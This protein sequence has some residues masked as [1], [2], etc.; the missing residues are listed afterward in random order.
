MIFLFSRMRLL[1]CIRCLLWCL[2]LTLPC[3]G[4]SHEEKWV[5]RVHPPAGMYRA[6]LHFLSY[7]A[8]PKLKGVVVVAPGMNGDPECYM[9]DQGWCEFIKSNDLLMV[10]IS[11]ASEYKDLHD[12]KGYY[13]PSSGSGKV[14]LEGLTR[15]GVGKL[16]MY[17][18]GFSGGAHFVSRFVRWHPDGI[19][20]WCAYSAAWWDR[21]MCKR[22]GVPGIVACGTL[23][24]RLSAS[25]TYFEQGRDCGEIWL[26]VAIE[27]VGH[28][29]SV[30]LESFFRDYAVGITRQSIGEMPNVG[31]W[32]N[33]N[34]GNIEEWKFANGF[35]CSTGWLPDGRLQKEWCRLNGRFL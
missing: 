30:E 26:W 21:P 15:Q 6:D 1:S 18:F 17:M 34:T 4:T 35:P 7:T 8:I 32:I 20:A 12:R 23:D 3:Q 22:N 33:I 11:F 28:E 24:I 27:S 16:P 29:R 9:E 13:Y 31:R 19:V 25:R 10:G 5:A 2:P 14:L